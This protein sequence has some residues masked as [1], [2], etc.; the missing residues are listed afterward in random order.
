M[1]NS[2][3]SVCAVIVSRNG[4]DWIGKALESLQRSTFPVRVVVVDNASTDDTVK[5]IREFYNE[6]ELLCMPTNLG[7]AA[8]NNH[9]IRYSLLQ[10]ADY[11]LLLNQD[12]KVE[13]RMIDSLVTLLEAHPDCGIISPLHL[14]YQGNGID[15][16]FF[17][18]IREDMSL[19]SDAFFWQLQ[20][21]YE[22]QFVNAAV[23]LV[24]QRVFRKVGGFDPLFFMYG[25]DQDYCRRV[26]YHGFK[27][28]FSPKAKA[29]HWHG[30]SPNKSSTLGEKCIRYY[31]EILHRLKRPGH[32]FILSLMGIAVTWVQRLLITLIYGDLKGFLAM[33]LSFCKVMP[34]LFTIWRH[35]RQCRISGNSWLGKD[36]DDSRAP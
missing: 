23:W 17:Q 21:L 8:A 33:V 6:V 10:G 16:L 19:V 15:Q 27:I 25:E 29:Y 2:K 5:T 32:N 30:G 18:H 11:I 24:S 12:A 14:D 26:L 35:Y 9:G 1:A 36:C 28:A 4:S 22:V 20:D 7:F 13:P 34:K 31:A 3:K